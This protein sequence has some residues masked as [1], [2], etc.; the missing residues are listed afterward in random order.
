MFTPKQI[1]LIEQIIDQRILSNESKQKP[2]RSKLFHTV[3]EIRKLIVD[4]E[5]RLRQLLGI[6]EFDIAVLRYELSKLTTLQDG[7]HEL[8]ISKK[9]AQ[10]R[11]DSQVLNALS[12]CDWPGCPLEQGSR[13]RSYRFKAIHPD[14][15]QMVQTP[16]EA[17][18]PEFR[19]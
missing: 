11:W 6:H 16:L 3:Q 5:A 10:K 15:S 2:Q 7:D 19:Q 18:M 13:R 12:G 14:A 4:N 8:L 9:T 1:Q 17:A